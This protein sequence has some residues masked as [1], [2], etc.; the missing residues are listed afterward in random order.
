MTDISNELDEVMNFNKKYESITP[1]NSPQQSCIENCIQEFESN[2]SNWKSI[3]GYLIKGKDCEDVYGAALLIYGTALSKNTQTNK[4]QIEAFQKEVTDFESKVKYK[5]NLKRSLWADVGLC[6][7]K[8][9]EDYES[10]VLSSLKKSQYYDFSDL[11]HTKYR[12]LTCY[13]FRKC[14][15]FLNQSLVNQSVPLS[16]PSTFNDIF[17]CPVFDMENTDEVSK[18]SKQALCQCLKIACFVRNISLPNKN[19]HDGS[20]KHPNDIEEYKN[21]LM[22]AHYADSHKG[23][24]IK[25]SFPSDFTKMGSNSNCEYVTFFHDVN[26]QDTL[27]D[28]KSEEGISYLDAFFTKSK[29]WEYENELRLLYFNPDNNDTYVS[30]PMENSIEAVYFGVNCSSIDRKTIINILKD[31]K[32]HFFNEKGEKIEKNIKFYQMKKDEKSYGSIVAEDISLPG[33]KKVGVNFL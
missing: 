8:L 26:Y 29:V 9:G 21:T 10:K 25:Y 6:W 31:V 11:N 17:D 15:H 19:N 14:S 24:C 16:S 20:P 27:P 23:I 28:V 7:N 18:I 12:Y 3:V 30:I 5:A 13:S 1:G 22:W 4:T 32:F 2:Y 33:K